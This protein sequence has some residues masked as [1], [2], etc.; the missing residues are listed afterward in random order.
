M[1]PCVPTRRSVLLAGFSC[2]TASW[3][4]MAQTRAAGPLRLFVG[5]PPRGATDVLARQVASQ[6]TG[7]E[8][9]MVENRAGA[10][11]RL[12]VGAAARAHADGLSVVVTRD[13]P[14]TLFPHL[15][16]KLGYDPLA[17]LVPVAVWGFSE[18]AFTVGPAV[19]AAVTTV[20]GFLQWARQN[21]KQAMYA[22]PSPG[23]A[24]HFTGVM[25]AAAARADLT[26]VAYKGGA[27]AIRDSRRPGAGEL[28][29]VGEVLPQ[30]AGGKLRVLATSGPHRPRF[31]PE[32]PTLREAGSSRRGGPELD[33][34]V[35][36][37]RRRRRPRSPFSSARCRKRSGAMQWPKALSSSA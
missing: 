11:G 3:P 6:M 19:P 22:S 26:H 7:Y 16:K 36:A 33:W 28:Q 14:I 24:P 23:S 27:Q 29:P 15:H 35:R 34:R 17:D 9:T 2:A 12:A 8:A 32:V 21:P 30:L 13:F 1:I 5:Y 37:K 4:A 18:M 10:G 20:A 25:L 31:L